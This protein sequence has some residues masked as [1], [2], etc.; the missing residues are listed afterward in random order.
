MARPFGSG[1]PFLLLTPLRFV[2][3]YP[4][5]SL[6]PGPSATLIPHGTLIHYFKEHSWSKTK[7]GAGFSAAVPV[8]S[9]PVF[10]AV[11]RD[12][13]MQS[14]MNSHKIRVV[15]NDYSSLE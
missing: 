15:N 14:I 8:T 2:V 5:L 13:L 7:P 9:P 10:P 1:Y 6:A 3:G 11:C 12:E 4:L